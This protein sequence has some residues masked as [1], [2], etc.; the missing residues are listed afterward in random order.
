MSTPHLQ[1]DIECPH[2]HQE[3]T[4]DGY[5]NVVKT[6]EQRTEESLANMNI[7]VPGPSQQEVAQAR[8]NRDVKMG[9]PVAEIPQGV[10][11]LLPEHPSS[12]FVG[13]MLVFVGVAILTWWCAKCGLFGRSNRRY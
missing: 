5:G 2:C 1:H 6:V 11:P 7:Q 13:L 8:F 4:V 10:V 9:K 12:G 3:I